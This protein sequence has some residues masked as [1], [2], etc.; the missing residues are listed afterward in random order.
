MS[1]EKKEKLIPL[2]EAA[3]IAGY[4][5]EHLNLCARK[6]RLKAEK[7][8][9]NWYTTISDLNSF[10]VK[11]DKRGDKRKK[12]EQYLADH[13]ADFSAPEKEAGGTRSMNMG[14]GKIF[15]GRRFFA[16]ASVIALAI[17]FAGIVQS[18]KISKE[19][20]AEFFGNDNPI[21]AEG[22]ED[23]FLSGEAKAVVLGEADERKADVEK[24]STAYASENFQA[25]EIR[26]GGSVGILSLADDLVPLEISGVKGES[27]RKGEDSEA[28]ILVTWSTSKPARTKITFAKF[29]GQG[30]KVFEEKF[31]DKSHAAVLARAD[32]GIAYHYQISARDKSG[33][34]KKSNTFAIY[35]GAREVSVFDVIAQA[36]NDIFGWTTKMR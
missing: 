34:E 16:Q 5:P 17:V 20:M 6:N 1:E 9:R 13:A 22:A 29:D 30:E 25:K 2:S 33:N 23:G 12:A 11:Y 18:G 19:K 35:S 15:S 27:F 10:V 24:I 4:A 28:K 32:L 36:A 26:M 14:A 21:W 8:G 7:L 31:Y 3:A